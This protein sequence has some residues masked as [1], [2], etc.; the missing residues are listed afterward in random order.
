MESG[1]EIIPTFG[2]AAAAIHQ[3]LLVADAEM[4]LTYAPRLSIISG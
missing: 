4:V 1:D 3:K 2:A